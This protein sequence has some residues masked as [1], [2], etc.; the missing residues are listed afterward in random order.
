MALDT[1]PALALRS[2]LC[3]RKQFILEEIARFARESTQ[4]EN[5]DDCLHRAFM[6]YEEI[7]TN[8][9]C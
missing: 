6:H 8:L 1:E 4:Q 7:I 3:L 9:E 2:R 5:G